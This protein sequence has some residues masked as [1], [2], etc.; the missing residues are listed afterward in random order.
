[1]GTSCTCMSAEIKALEDYDV[2][3]KDEPILIQDTAIVPKEKT[4]SVQSVMRGFKARSEG[5]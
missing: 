5:K 1:M 2:E 3:T 4:A